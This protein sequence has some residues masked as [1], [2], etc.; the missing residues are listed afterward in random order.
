[1]LILNLS[2]KQIISLLISVSGFLP[3]RDSSIYQSAVTIP[4]A[5][6]KFYPLPQQEM[7]LSY[8]R[9]QS[10]LASGRFN[11]A[12]IEFNR[13]IDIKPDIQDFYYSK[14]ICEE[15]LYKWDDA[16][17]D[18]KKAIEISRKN[19]LSRDDPYLFNNLANA[20]EGKGD[21]NQ[22]LIDFTYAASLDSN[23]EAPQ[24]SKALILFQLG[25]VNEAIMY[26][27]NLHVKYPNYPD[28]NA[29]L[30]LLIQDTDNERAKKL[31]A[32]VL[33]QD[34]RYGDLDWI[35]NIRRWPPKLVDTFIKFNS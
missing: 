31:W 15:K 33:I 21:Y 17:N 24:L 12:L 20:E 14:G 2:T 11:E 19:F 22:A 3:S 16:I 13:A 28:G 6:T 18:Y 4:N 10:Y 32:D 7:T 8:S 30:G 26:F 29:V 34:S 23:F 9:G 1:M 5:I 27:E 25:K 35:T